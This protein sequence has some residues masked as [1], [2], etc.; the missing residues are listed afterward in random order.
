MFFLPLKGKWSACCVCQLHLCMRTALECGW[1]NQYHSAEESWCSLPQSHLL[2]IV[3]W[4]GVRLFP[5]LCWDFDWLAIVQV[6]QCP[7]LWVPVCLF[8]TV[9][10]IR[11]CGNITEVI[12]FWLLHSF[13]LSPYD[14]FPELEGCSCDINMSFRAELPEVSHSVSEMSSSESLST[15][16]LLQKESFLM[17][18]EQ[19]ASL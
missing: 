2:W 5:F 10:G 1:Y 19:C 18:V 8:P 6:V 4:V 11:C 13:C 14:R 7:S 15:H 3:S 9:S 12:Y 16:H 17:R